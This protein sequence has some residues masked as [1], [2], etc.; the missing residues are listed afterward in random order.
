MKHKCEII[1]Q[2]CASW[3]KHELLMGSRNTLCTFSIDWKVITPQFLPHFVMLQTYYKTKVQV[4]VY[5]KLPLKR[6]VLLFM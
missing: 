6:V 1:S 4:V 2:I 5:T 3:G